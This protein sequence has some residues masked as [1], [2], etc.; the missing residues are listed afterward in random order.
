[1]TVHALQSVLRVFHY[2]K[3]PSQMW[4]GILWRDAVH[5]RSRNGSVGFMGVLESTKS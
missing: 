1:M 3:N 4:Y 2:S 5:K